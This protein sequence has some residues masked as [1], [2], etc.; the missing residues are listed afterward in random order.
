MNTVVYKIAL[1]DKLDTSN[2][3]LVVSNKL[4]LS[5]HTYLKARLKTARYSQ[6]LEFLYFNNRLVTTKSQ[7]AKYP[8]L[9]L[10]SPTFTDIAKLNDYENSNPFKP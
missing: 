10:Q 6:P 7:L 3:P 1:F 4:W 2:S 9:K 5:Y 8:D